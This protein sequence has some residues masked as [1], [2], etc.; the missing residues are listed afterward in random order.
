MRLFNCHETLDPSVSII[1]KASIRSFGGLK[2][3]FFVSWDLW[4][5]NM[6]PLTK[7]SSFW[8]L[9]KAIPAVSLYPSLLGNWFHVKH[10]STFWQHENGYETLGSRVPWFRCVTF[11][12]FE[13]PKTR[14]L[15][16]LFRHF[17]GLKKRFLPC[18]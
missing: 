15:K 12:Y 5:K 10:C 14:L 7:F 9:E 2:M 8:R 6:F 16:C 1:H 3:R 11:R 4:L 13:G 18:R 17:G